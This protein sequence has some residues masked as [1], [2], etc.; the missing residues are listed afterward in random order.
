MEYLKCIKGQFIILRNYRDAFNLEKFADKYLEEYFDK[1]N[2]IVGDISS[3]ILRLK[4]FSENPKSPNYYA[5]I[6]EYLDSSCAYGCPFY[7]LKRIGSY[8]EYEKFKKEYKEK[9]E[10]ERIKIYIAEKENFDKENLVL[11]I[12]EK[13]NRPININMDDLTKITV[14]KLPLDLI[15]KNDKKPVENV[16][17][18]EVE[19]QTYV[20]ASPDFDPSLKK[21]QKS[22]NM[23]RPNKKNNKNRDNKNARR[24]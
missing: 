10:E 18:V 15:E 3:S 11:S 5:K 17:K 16:E 7:V 1:Y 19:T 14:G 24:K 6:D 9:P 22:K 20:S 13:T 23:C 2:Y 8:E 4:G 21:E 12:S